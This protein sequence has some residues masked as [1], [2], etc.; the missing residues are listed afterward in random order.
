[1]GFHPQNMTRSQL[2]QD[3]VNEQEDV[4]SEACDMTSTA[5]YDNDGSIGPDL[6]DNGIGLAM[7]ARDYDPNAIVFFAFGDFG[8]ACY[9]QYG[10]D[11]ADAVRRLRETIEKLD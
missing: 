6:I 11:E 2:L 7:A 8:D 5:G 3:F 10:R 4:A 1:M 9:Y